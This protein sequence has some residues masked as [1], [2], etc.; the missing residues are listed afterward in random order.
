MIR[1]FKSPARQAVLSFFLLVTTYAGHSQ[2]HVEFRELNFDQAIEAAKKENKIVFVDVRGLNTAPMT[3]QVDEKIFTTD[4]IA[5][6]LNSSCIPIRVNMGTE[7]GKKFAPKLA[8]LMYPVYVFYGSGGDQLEFTNAASILK[9]PGELMQKA[10]NSLMIDLAKKQ[11]TR[12]IKFSESRWASILAQAK[13]EN[14]LIFVDAYTEWCRPC[15][16]MARNV[17]TLDKVAD[18]YNQNFVNV[19]LDMEKGEGP[20]LNKKYKVAAYPTYLF[21]N[22]DG[23]IVYQEGGY[24]EPDVFINTGKAAL[25]K[26]RK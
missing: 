18:F 10:Q 13:K 21:I 17:F 16:L 2:Q 11:N 15:I 4:S 25:A 26:Q 7:E 19:S 1:K 3:K 23:K 24:K 6:F 20:E 14:K 5:H 22:G 8:M 9:D 12:S